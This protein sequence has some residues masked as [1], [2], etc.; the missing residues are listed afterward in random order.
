MSS[1]LEWF[2]LPRDADE[3]AL[4]RAYAQRLR[5][6]RPDENP[7]GFQQLHAMYQ[8]A[9]AECRSQ[10]GE[11]VAFPLEPSGASPAEATREQALDAQAADEG[12][13]EV[14]PSREQVDRLVQ[15]AI[16]LAAEGDVASLLTWLRARPELWSLQA[17][18]MVGRRCVECLFQQVPPMPGECLQTLL[19][20]FDLDRV[21]ARIDA[22][23][24]A[25]LSRRMRL[26]WELQPCNREA[27]RQRLGATTYTPRMLQRLLDEFTRPFQRRSVCISGTLPSMARN[28]ANF[29]SLLC[30]GHYDELPPSFDRKR[31]Q[32]WK[33]A[34][35]PGLTRAR[36]ALALHRWLFAMS[37][38]LLLGI[39][40]LL[41]QLFDDIHSDAAAPL[42]L[43]PLPWLFGI[44]SV[45]GAIWLLWVG[46][47]QLDAWHNHPE[48]IDVRWPWLN[49]LLVPVLC[50][51]SVALKLWQPDNLAFLLP[52]LPAAWLAL[53]RFWRRSATGEW[54][55]PNMLRVGFFLAVPTLRALFQQDVSFLLLMA[56]AL[57]S[58]S[59]DLWRQRAEL[60]VVT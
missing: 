28:R 58:W 20:F 11:E 15:Q 59:W 51:A 26:A 10:S 3:R 1:P 44:A 42:D 41:P 32:F 53:R 17:K 4:K 25:R 45:P 49:L 29:I 57:I 38:A 24:L 12:I 54:L 35:Q 14:V 31:I 8:R 55:S 9:L 13:V 47:M 5:T 56:L 30:Q 37:I 34:V 39:G 60:R 27:L 52:L 43:S 40:V 2:G 18:A 48:H 23:A 22:M 19:A 6:T 46:Y 21:Q 50:A 33:D 16:A 7:E 36:M